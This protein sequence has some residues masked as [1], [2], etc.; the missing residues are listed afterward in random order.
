MYFIG[1]ITAF[2]EV[3]KSLDNSKKT[4]ELKCNQGLDSGIL[5]HSVN[6]HFALFCQVNLCIIKC[7]NYALNSCRVSF[8]HFVVIIRLVHKVGGSFIILFTK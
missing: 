3:K 6:N 5:F 7:L 4:W 2:K 1:Q 8:V